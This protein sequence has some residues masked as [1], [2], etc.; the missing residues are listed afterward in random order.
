LYLS[1]E[2]RLDTPNLS[3]TQRND[4]P[5]GEGQPC[6]VSWLASS[7]TASPPCQTP[8]ISDLAKSEVRPTIHLASHELI[9]LSRVNRR[10]PV[11]VKDKPVHPAT[12]YRW[13]TR[14]VRA[15]DG[16][17]VRLETI[18]VGGV[19]YTSC[20]ALQRFCDRLSAGA[21]DVS[22]VVPPARL[23]PAARMAAEECDRHGL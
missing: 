13:A 3:G 7:R 4:A 19:L 12:P 6:R 9:K 20:E 21:T 1:S 11:G 14:G 10:L 2:H 8:R 15:A 18:R 16:T 17:V 23:S 5:T 22:H